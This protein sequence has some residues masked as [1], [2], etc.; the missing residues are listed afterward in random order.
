MTLI[1]FIDD[2][3]MSSD[4]LVLS[5]DGKT[6]ATIPQGDETAL[7]LV[8]DYLGGEV[9]REILDGDSWTVYVQAKPLAQQKPEVVLGYPG[10]VEDEAA[11]SADWRS[12]EPKASSKQL[13]FLY[14]NIRLYL[15]LKKPNWPGDP[16]NLLRYEASDAMTTIM[17]YM[18][19]SKKAKKS[20][21]GGDDDE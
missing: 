4:I 10:E 19:K 21:G 5:S 14:K 20:R 15:M 17:N 2:H 7:S 18:R 3:L 16:K 13:S 12:R 9:L 1:D 8:R 6:V 11:F